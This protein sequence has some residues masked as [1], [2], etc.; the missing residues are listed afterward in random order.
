M[1]NQQCCSRQL[2][3]VEF[4][5]KAWP[6][7]NDNVVVTMVWQ[8]CGV[9]PSP[10]SPLVSPGQIYIS[11]LPFTP[12]GM[13]TSV[14]ASRLLSCRT[15]LPLL[16]LL[17]AITYVARGQEQGEQDP[18]VPAYGG[19]LAI[20]Y[21]PP[22]G[23]CLRSLLPLPPPPVSIVLRACTSKAVMLIGLK[24]HPAAELTT[25]PY[26]LPPVHMQACA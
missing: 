21:G 24:G 15:L 13:G 9:L 18:R 14:G 19:S 7:A 4:K 16:L 3:V 11:R 6:T 26:P 10:P 8:G 1:A 22:L 12:S 17:V 2:A 5:I 25:I 20:G 23:P